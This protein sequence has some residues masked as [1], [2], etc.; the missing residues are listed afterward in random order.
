MIGI[1]PILDPRAGEILG[2]VFKHY[3][4]HI[5]YGQ[6]Q[7]TQAK[8]IPKG[9]KGPRYDI[10][11]S[12]EYTLPL[13]VALWYAILAVLSQDFTGVLVLVS[14]LLA[15][16][17]KYWVP[18][19]DLITRIPPHLALRAFY[20]ALI[21]MLFKILE[22]TDKTLAWILMLLVGFKMAHISAT[23]LNHWAS[24]YCETEAW[25]WPDGTPERNI[26]TWKKLYENDPPEQGGVRTDGRRGGSS[27]AAEPRPG[28]YKSSYDYVL[29]NP[30][31]AMHREGR[32]YI[33]ED[34]ELSEPEVH[35]R[36][37]ES[38]EEAFYNA[39]GRRE[40]EPEIIV[41]PSKLQFSAFA[42]YN[43]LINHKQ[44][45]AAQRLKKS[46]TPNSPAVRPPSL[47]P[48]LHPLQ[49]SLTP[50]RL[51]PLPDPTPNSQPPQNP[52]WQPF[53]PLPPTKTPHPTL[54]PNR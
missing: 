9:V 21:L 6:M 32:K 18:G 47:P 44:D 26:K 28:D 36:G 53:T 51:L 50:T 33:Y 38:E 10:I 11:I 40:F 31:T 13:L 17:P 35:Y 48:S 34:E 2:N 43:K 15:A 12:L 1:I 46:L 14:L 19:S 3:F 37:E 16:E 41:H 23:G 54:H 22:I 8:P 20:T 4:C 25:Y 29:A 45:P 52:P 42:Q 30:N 5:G 27:R 24:M 7:S 49:K 39:D